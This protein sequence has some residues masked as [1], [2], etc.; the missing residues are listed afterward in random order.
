ME[1]RKVLNIIVNAYFVIFGIFVV[2][3]ILFASANRVTRIAVFKERI[4]VSLIFVIL[5]GVLFRFYQQIGGPFYSMQFSFYKKLFTEEH[6]I[7]TLKKMGLFL[8]VVGV[9][10]ISLGTVLYFISAPK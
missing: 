2:F 6:V 7:N 9:S 10:I 5:G 3:F 8:L 4:L 1:R